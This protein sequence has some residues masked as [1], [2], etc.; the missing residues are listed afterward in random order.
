MDGIKYLLQCL[1]KKTSFQSFIK[2][3]YVELKTFGNRFSL[4]ISRVESADSETLTFT[5]ILDVE[6]N[7]T[8][9]ERDLAIKLCKEYLEG[10]KVESQM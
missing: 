4:K 2:D 7:N 1:E 3:Y 8:S 9:E 6:L 10:A 5:K